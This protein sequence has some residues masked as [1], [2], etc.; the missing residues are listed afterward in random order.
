MYTVKRVNSI[1]NRDEFWQLA[2]SVD[3]SEEQEAKYQKFVSEW[4]WRLWVEQG[5]MYIRVHGDVLESLT[6]Y[7]NRQEQPN[8]SAFGEPFSCIGHIGSSG[9]NVQNI[10]YVMPTVDTG[11]QSTDDHINFPNNIVEVYG[12]YTSPQL[13]ET[14]LLL[15]KLNTGKFFFFHAWCDCSGFES[16]S[17]IRLYICTDYQLLVDNGLTQD[18][19]SRTG[20]E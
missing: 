8:L 12:Q 19:R 15:G 18:D 14:W 2:M 5:N 20:I 6:D 4:D 11:L 13:N 16:V 10:Y 7:Q 17:E 9:Y 3:R 1:K